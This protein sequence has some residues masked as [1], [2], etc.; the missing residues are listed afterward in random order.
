MKSL[1]RALSQ[2]TTNDGGARLEQSVRNQLSGGSLPLIEG[3]GA[4]RFGQLLDVTREDAV[5]AQ[6]RNELSHTRPGCFDAERSLQRKPVFEG[7]RCCHEFDAKDHL[8]V[9]DDVAQ[10]ER[11]RHTHG[12][13]VLLA[14]GRGHRVD[15]CGMSEDLALVE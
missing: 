14:A 3:A 8:R 4:Y 11:R 9:L 13:V 5:L 1:P 10:L 12:D 2:P 15:A 7:L 6:R